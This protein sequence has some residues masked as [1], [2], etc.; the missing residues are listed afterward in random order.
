MINKGAF[1]IASLK[2]CIS[3]VIL[4]VH[5]VQG[6]LVLPVAADFKPQYLSCVYIEKSTYWTVEEFEIT[7][8]K[9]LI[10]YSFSIEQSTYWIVE[11]DV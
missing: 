11:E 4:S 9:L 8:P 5:R 6:S 10:I 2:I 3:I 1:D 7:C